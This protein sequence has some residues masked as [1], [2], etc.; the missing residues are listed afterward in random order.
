M[1]ASAFIASSNVENVD[2]TQPAH[3]QMATVRRDIGSPLLEDTIW[4]ETFKFRLTSKKT[5]RKIDLNIK[6]NLNSE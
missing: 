3:T 4:G 1:S 2:F 6:Y 5:G